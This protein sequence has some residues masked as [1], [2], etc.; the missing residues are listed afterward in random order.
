M[1]QQLAENH[2]LSTVA[3]IPSLG[4]EQEARTDVDSS[5]ELDPISDFDQNEYQD[6]DSKDAVEREMNDQDQQSDSYPP[7]VTGVNKNS[8]ACY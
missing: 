8:E 3:Q 1:E 4:L 5:Y 7:H 2:F 6:Q